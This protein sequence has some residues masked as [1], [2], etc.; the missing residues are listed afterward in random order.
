LTNSRCFTSKINVVAKNVHIKVKTK[1][2][3][4]YNFFGNQN[5]A[6]WLFEVRNGQISINLD[7]CIM[8]PKQIVIFEGMVSLIQKIYG[9]IHDTL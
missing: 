4:G 3:L 1:Y 8:L 7:G 9:S 2:S 5:F 6:N